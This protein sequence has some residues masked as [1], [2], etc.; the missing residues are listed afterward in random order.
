MAQEAIP[1]HRDGAFRSADARARLAVLLLFFIEGVTLGSWTSR[2]PD[3][4]H[5]VGLGD[6]GWGLSYFAAT[7]GELV[8][9]AAIT[10]LI[11]RTRTPRLSLVGAVLVLLSAPLAASAPTLPALLIGI[12]VYGFAATLLSTPANVQAVEVERRY[13]RPLMSTFHGSF[14]IGMLAGGGLGVVAVA[15]GVRPGVQLAVS[16]VLLCFLLVMSYRWHPDDSSSRSGSSGPRRRLRDRFT[17]RLVLLA[18]LAFLASFSEGAGAYWSAIYT[19]DTIGA[20]AAMGAI[21]YTSMSA[22][23]AATRLVGDQVA[24]RLGRRRLIQVSSVVTAAGIALA[25]SVAHPAAAI[26]GFAVFGIGVACTL[27][28]IFGLVGEQRGVSAGEGVSVVALGQWPAFLAAP[29][30]IGALAGVVD[31]RAAL[32]LVI[33]SAVAVIMLVGRVRP[34]RTDGDGP[35][36]QSKPPAAQGEKA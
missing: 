15:L 30:L 34:T 9:L 20:G 31:L 7:A 18:A 27:P 35:A 3:V 23:L 22:G 32:L 29:A 36:H 1:A 12:L 4:R 16:S 26:A 8:A 21:A 13:G 17:P 6:T 5:G 28:T 25:L 11:G 33:V 10:L 19:A 2:A 14:S 24:A